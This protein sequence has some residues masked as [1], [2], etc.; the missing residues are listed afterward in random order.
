MDGAA[1]LAVDLQHQ[2]DFVLHQ[3]RFIDLRP[4]GIEQVAQALRRSPAHHRVCVMCGVAGYRQRSRMPKP[5]I[6]ATPAPRRP[7]LEV[8]QRVEHLH[9]PDTTVLYC[10]RW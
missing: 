7:G 10:M 5:S 3:R 2:L 1:Q 9:A 4:L 8:F 6:S